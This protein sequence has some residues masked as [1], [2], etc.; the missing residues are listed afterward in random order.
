MKT[1][2]VFLMFQVYL[3]YQNKQTKEIGYWF[4][5]DLAGILK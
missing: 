2:A 3:I 1:N 5:L 4:F